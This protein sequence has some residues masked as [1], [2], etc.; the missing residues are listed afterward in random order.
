MRLV[1]NLARNRRLLAASSIALLSVV[2][3]AMPASAECTRLGFSVNDYGKD[4]PSK[5]ASN[6][7]DKHIAKK[8]AERG[9]SNYTTGKRS[10]TCELY[11]DVILFD[12]YTCTAEATVCWGGSV[13]AKDETA[14]AATKSSTSKASD[15]KP[16]EAKP[17]E[18]KPVEA[19]PADAKPADAKPSDTKPSDT[20]PAAN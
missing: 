20:T 13:P 2:S 18:A 5:D 7:L 6:L 19:T 15:A 9:V 14:A 12:E 16:V 4:G 3:A 11:L 8:M 10:V 1:G 17:A